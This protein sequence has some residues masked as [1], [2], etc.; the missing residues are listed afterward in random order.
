VPVARTIEE[1]GF[2]AI[3]GAAAKLDVV[4][5]RLAARSSRMDMMELD[6]APRVAP[7]SVR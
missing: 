3:V 5:R 1:L 4:R 6:E 7:M 2:V